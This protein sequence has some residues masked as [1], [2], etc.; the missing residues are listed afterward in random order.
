M[1][2]VPAEAAWPDDSAGVAR[3]TGPAYGGVTRRGGAAGEGRTGA[4]GVGVGRGLGEAAGAAAG[5]AGRMNGVAPAKGTEEGPRGANGAGGLVGGAVAGREALCETGA[6]GRMNGGAAGR[7]PPAIAGAAFARGTFDGALGDAMGAAGG[8]LGR[9]SGEAVGAAGRA[10]PLGAAPAAVGADDIGVGARA[11]TG[12]A[13]EAAGVGD[14]ANSVPS[15]A[16][17]AIAITPPQ[18]E[19]R[20]RTLAAGTLSGSTRKT[21]R[22]SGQTTFIPSLRSSRRSTDRRSVPCRRA[23]C[24]CGG[25]PS[26]PSRAM[27]SRSSSSPWQA[28]SPVPHA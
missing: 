8:M 12:G 16:L 5:A 14:A 23:G 11:G 27:S 9:A 22:H 10:A 15:C 19:H 25:P 4:A 21:E 24:R 3:T 2:C 20:A 18:T 28:R 26:T 1:E 7:W 17:R 13:F 6:A